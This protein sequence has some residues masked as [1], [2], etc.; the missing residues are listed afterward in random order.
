MAELYPKNAGT[1]NCEGLWPPTAESADLKITITPK[2][3]AVLVYTPATGPNG[4]RFDGPEATKRIPVRGH[5][6]YV[7]KIS[8]CETFSVAPVGWR[9]S[10]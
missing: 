1:F 9:D 6:M 2:D 4:I 3:G 10:L 7:Q 8:G 5:T